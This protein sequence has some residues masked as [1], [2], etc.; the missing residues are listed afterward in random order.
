MGRNCKKLLSVFI[1]SLSKFKK[2]STLLLHLNFD[3]VQPHFIQT[4][5]YARKFIIVTCEKSRFSCWRFLAPVQPICDGDN[6][7]VADVT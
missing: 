4:S 6:A 2:I 5:D 7:K 1:A 3:T